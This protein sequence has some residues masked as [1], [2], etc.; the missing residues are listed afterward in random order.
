MTKSTLLG[1]VILIVGLMLLTR[2]YFGH[3][4]SLV[5]G[6]IAFLLGA[7]IA[8]GGYVSGVQEKRQKEIKELDVMVVTTDT[9]PGKKIVRVLGLVHARNSALLSYRMA[10]RWLEQ[11]TESDTRRN[12]LKEARALGANAIVGVK[13]ERHEERGDVTYY[14]YGT[15]V[16][17]E[18]EH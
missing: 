9:I 3:S 15:A 6:G 16:I 1:I 18:D 14:M 11:A 4:Q 13:T 10:G 8:V 17:A 5:A 7:A 12:L 2:G